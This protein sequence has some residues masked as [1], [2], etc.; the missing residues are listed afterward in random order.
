M[1]VFKKDLM[2]ERLK[3]EKMLDTVDDKVLE[4]MNRLDGKQVKKNDWKALLYGEVEYFCKD[5]DGKT[6]A[7]HSDDIIRINDRE[8]ER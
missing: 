6:Y 1:L 3:K 2:I 8:R 7:I 4:L 5:D